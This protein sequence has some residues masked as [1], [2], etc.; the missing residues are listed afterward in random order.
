MAQQLQDLQKECEKHGEL[1][2]NQLQALD[3]LHQTHRETLEEADKLKMDVS[4]NS[5]RVLSD[6]GWVL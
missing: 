4:L 2:N 6:F 3:K 1:A 5:A